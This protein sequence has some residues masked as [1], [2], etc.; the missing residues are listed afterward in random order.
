MI[1]GDRKSGNAADRESPGTSAQADGN[2]LV[3]QDELGSLPTRAER[4]T[5]CIGVS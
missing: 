3:G 5:G 4:H 1:K 2:S